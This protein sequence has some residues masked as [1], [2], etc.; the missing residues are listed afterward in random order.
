VAHPLAV[1]VGALLFLAFAAAPALAAPTAPSPPPGWSDPMPGHAPG[2]APPASGTA[3]AYD[4]DSAYRLLAFVDEPPPTLDDLDALGPA[5]SYPRGTYDNMLAAWRDE[6]RAKHS[7][8]DWPEFVKS[9]VQLFDAK[10]TGDGYALHQFTQLGIAGSSKWIFDRKPP[11]S[12]VGRRPDAFPLD[13]A[14][15]RGFEAK[16]TSELNSKSRAQL[17]DYVKQVDATG[18]QMVYLFRLPPD[19][20]ALALV[21]QANLASKYNAGRT[22]ATAVNAIVARY[23]PA[24]PQ[25]AA[26]H[27]PVADEK[28]AEIAQR[29]AP[30]PAAS[31]AATGRATPGAT[32]TQGGNAGATGG[33]P[34]PVKPNGGAGVLVAPDSGQLPVDGALS[35]A[36]GYSPDSPQEAATRQAM[37]DELA[38][39]Y[40]DEEEPDAAPLGGVDFSTLEL[41]YVSD[42]YQGGSGLRYAFSAEPGP[43][44]QPSYGGRQAALLASD[45]F[46]VWL[47]LPTSDFTVNLNPD[48]P[49]RIIDAK[50][51][52]TDAG[53]VL[54]EADL[55]M[56]KTVGKL[57]HPD[58]PAGARYWA[59]LEGDTRCVSMRQWIVPA[60]ATVREDGGQLYILDAPL[61]VKMETDYVKTKGVGDTSGCPGQSDA[62]TQH[63]EAVY[64]S[65]ILPQVQQAVNTAP[66]YADLRRV[67]VSRVAAQWYRERSSTRHTAYGGLVDQGDVSNWP[68]RTPW[69]PKDVF[70]QY[71]QSYTKGEFT[72]THTT[73]QGNVV[74][75]MTYV[76]GGVD[77]SNIPRTRLSGT[78]FA[79]RRPAL[80]ATA[81]TA[82]FAPMTE[83]GSK[84]IWLG[85]QSTP[86]PLTEIQ[87]GVPAA[88]SAP[89]FW[90]VTTLPLLL[91]VIA[92]VVLFARRRRKVGA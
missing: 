69:S 81:S 43:A 78:S 64:R 67:Y 28:L 83:P 76:Y 66:E 33:G 20:T 25:P 31:G 3:P 62:E 41:R 92:G 30:S 79:N 74:H 51:G 61:T 75:T 38:T 77:F 86:R 11:G 57:I 49:D 50:F 45:A 87:A 84:L 34:A 6:G 37:L 2:T 80:A 85:G 60:P 58:T 23:A 29:A 24:T 12:P 46:F 19:D 17:R 27:D 15:T 70:N 9:Y 32:G 18:K 53:R 82:A 73:R 21:E 68:A 47:E 55:Q 71:V 16:S 26:V 40:G 59:A 89:S 52:Q 48:E 90:I 10:S 44:D 35:D 8:A 63:N 1:F 72:V 7:D 65:T 42:T 36:V 88:T 14:Q 22:A 54:L 13:P 56:K 39:Y 4:Y 91:W 5:K